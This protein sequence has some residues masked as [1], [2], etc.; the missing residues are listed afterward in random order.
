MKCPNCGQGMMKHDDGT[1]ACY[2][3]RMEVH[4]DV[5]RPSGILHYTGLTPT[6]EEIHDDVN[7]PSHYT[8]GR[9]Y[10]PIDVIEDWELGFNLGNAVKYISRAGRKDDIVQDLEKARWYLER[11]IKRLRE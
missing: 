8:E 11:E 1:Y 10:E 6:V 2:P 9:K 3:C 7:K 4:D 5:H